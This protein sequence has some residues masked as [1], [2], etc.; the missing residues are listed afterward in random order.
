MTGADSSFSSCDGSSVGRAMLGLAAA[1]W[2]A[3]AAAPPSVVAQ[4][5]ARE[6][7]VYATDLPR[8]ALSEFEVWNDAASPGGKLV[9]TPNT[10]GNLD[11]PPEADPHVTFKVTVEGGVPYRCWVHMKVGTPRGLSR[12][13]VLWVQVSDAVDQSGR[14]ILK[15]DTRSYL[16]AR[17][18]SAP[19]WAWVPCNSS[20]PGADHLIRF[21]AD[22]Q[23]TVRLQAGMEGVG[24]DQFVLSPARYLDSA[25]TD[26]VVPKP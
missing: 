26:A 9:G 21:R 7:V 1:V 17:G 14:Q 2:I 10:G 16:T 5:A 6:V 15:P 22:G 20:E 18:P 24:F 13:N 19:G 25:P 8:R 11:P 3:G 23:V 12:A 4:A